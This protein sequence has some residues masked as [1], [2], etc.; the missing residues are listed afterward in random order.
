MGQQLQSSAM[1]KEMQNLAATALPNSYS[2]LVLRLG[3]VKYINLRREQIFTGT[4]P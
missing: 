2:S 3:V 1:G 4:R